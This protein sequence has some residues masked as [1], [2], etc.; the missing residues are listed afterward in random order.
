MPNTAVTEVGGLVHK[1]ITLFRR[2]NF[3][4]NR[5]VAEVS[6]SVNKYRKFFRRPDPTPVVCAAER[7]G[8]YIRNNIG[9]V[10]SV[11]NVPVTGSQALGSS[12]R[13]GR[14][15][16]WWT[17]LPSHGIGSAAVS[18]ILLLLLMVDSDD[19]NVVTLLIQPPSMQLHSI[20]NMI[21]V[22]K[23]SFFKVGKVRLAPFHICIYINSVVPKCCSI[24]LHYVYSLE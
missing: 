20:D 23:G 11:C 15:C 4:P 18:L 19:S 14:C 6:D 10:P 12:H 9:A 2:T 21:R 24:I 22:P 17:A 3:P 8:G 7:N 1:H 5:V 16:L 13:L